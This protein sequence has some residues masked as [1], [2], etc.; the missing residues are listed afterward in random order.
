MNDDAQRAESR[1]RV[2]AVLASSERALA[3]PR[4]AGELWRL[5][6]TPDAHVVERRVTPPAA[7]PRPAGGAY[8]S[9]AAFE[10]RMGAFEEAVGRM[11]AVERMAWQRRFAEAER[12]ISELEARV[13]EGEP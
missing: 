6:Q 7:S 10:R 1:A 8:I 4:A 2:H 11:F 13:A 12:R 3:A 9:K 5:P